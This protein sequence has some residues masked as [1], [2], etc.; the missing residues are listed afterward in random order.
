[1]LQSELAV[2]ITFDE[3]GKAELQNALNTLAD[4]RDAFTKSGCACN[5]EKGYLAGAM[6][7]LKDILD[8]RTIGG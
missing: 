4:V 5:M 6:E 1:M 8:G 7:V 3:K 2:Q